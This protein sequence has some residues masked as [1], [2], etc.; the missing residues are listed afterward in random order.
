[1]TAPLFSVVIPTLDRSNHV[2]SL[3]RDLLSNQ[4]CR[5]FDITVVDDG[6][7]DDTV[8]RLRRIE[9]RRLTIVEREHGGVCARRNDGAAKSRGEWLVFLDSDDLVDP[10]WLE[11]FQRL[12]SDDV[13]VVSIAQRRKVDS[14]VSVRRP[15]VEGPMLA[16]LD[17]L[18]QAGAFAIR[19]SLFDEVGGYAVGLEFSENTELGL[20]IAARSD[21]RTVR[22][23]IDLDPHYTVI[24]RPDR[25]DASRRMV[26]AEFILDRHGDRLALEPDT[27]ATYHAMAGVAA[28]KLDL[29]TAAT[30]H[31]QCAVR[32][33]PRSFRNR[34]RLMRALVR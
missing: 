16:R 24:V 18:W 7:T 25:Y 31:L 27:H 33:R 23:A 4:R 6:S 2:T 9:D 21:M 29:R 15:S 1:M 19:R 8:S 34:L 3:V 11:S 32:L 13:D 17:V 28:G 26:S 10:D 5:D 30:S 14:E 22:T 12:I 20:R